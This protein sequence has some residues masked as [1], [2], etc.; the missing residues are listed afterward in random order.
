MLCNMWTI[1]S[2]FIFIIYLDNLFLT[3]KLLHLRVP[4]SYIISTVIYLII[5]V[6]DTKMKHLRVLWP[7]AYSC[8]FYSAAVVLVIA[9]SVLVCCY[10]FPLKAFFL[11]VH[12]SSSCN[13]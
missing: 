1:I 10:S 8:S 9:V 6:G 7:L 2:L 4:F 12:S 11:G 5:N 3:T 13:R